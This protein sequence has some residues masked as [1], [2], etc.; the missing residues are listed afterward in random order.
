MSKV[1][2]PSTPDQMKDFGLTSSGGHRQKPCC[3]Q[4]HGGSV[5]TSPRGTS[6]PYLKDV[7]TPSSFEKQKDLRGRK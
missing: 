7:E 2:M 5:D 6:G 1:Q 3:H 4:G